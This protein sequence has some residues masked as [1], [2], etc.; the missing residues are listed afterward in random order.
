MLTL[1]FIQAV[2]YALDT[3]GTKSAAPS[4]SASSG[5]SASGSSSSYVLT[6]SEAYRKCRNRFATQR[7]LP[8]KSPIYTLDTS[9]T[10][11]VVDANNA[12]GGNI[13][14]LG[15]GL[16][17]VAGHALIERDGADIKTRHFACGINTSNG[18]L[19]SN[20]GK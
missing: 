14:Q 6:E 17:V 18:S 5:A 1:F 4:S 11:L 7:D 16:I 20:E 19:L 15:N 2:A 12:N 9:L 13:T 3:E 8:Y 10:S